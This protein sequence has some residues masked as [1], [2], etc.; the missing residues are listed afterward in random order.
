MT[1]T[2]KVENTCCSVHSLVDI[3]SA[4]WAAR[5]KAQ[6]IRMALFAALLGLL[7]VLALAFAHA[8]E[9]PASA[10]RAKCF[11]TFGTAQW[12]KWIGC[13]MAA[14]ESLA[15]G[16]IG[17]WAAI[18]AA[19]LAYSGIQMQIEEGRRN[20]QTQIE[21]D[22]RKTAMSEIAAKA[23]ALAAITQTIHATAETLFAVTQAQKAKD[24]QEIEKWDGLVKQGTSYIEECLSNFI[25]RE[26]VRDLRIDDR[27]L[28]VAIVARLSTFVT[29]NKHPSE[30]LN[31]AA[32]L[33]NQYT[34]LM[35][36]R[37]Y[38]R[39]FDSDLAAVYARDSGIAP[40]S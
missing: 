9:L 12:P 27:V 22:R 35:N 5:L 18:S 38:L 3:S 2:G 32:R 26:A 37:D 25:V 19:W 17:L 1:P 7:A 20:I 30:H 21:E 4:V 13:A 29:I 15:A 14:H 31:R 6:L 11:E 40:Q 24:Q 16:L 36:L 23:A 8:W 33:Q 39:P 28:Y 34:T 10:P